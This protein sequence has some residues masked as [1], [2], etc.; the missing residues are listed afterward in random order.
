MNDKRLTVFRTEALE[1]DFVTASGLTASHKTTYSL[2]STGEEAMRVANAAAARN[3]HLSEAMKKVRA[4]M[5]GNGS[6]PV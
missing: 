6:V 5:D 2:T 4:Q 1:R 3:G